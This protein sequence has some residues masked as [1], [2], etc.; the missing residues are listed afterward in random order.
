MRAFRY[1]G[2]PGRVVFGAGA[3]GEA[4]AEVEALGRSRALLLSTP[5]QAADLA[6]LA[7][8]LGPRAAGCFTAAA[9]H[10]PT[11][12]T[13]AAM[14]AY[15]Q[16][17]ADCVLALGGGSTIGLGKAIAWRNDAPQLVIATTYAGSEVTDI[18]GQTEDGVKTTLR[19]PRIRPET[20]IYDPELTLGLPVAMSVASGLNAMAHAIEGLYAPDANPVTSLMA[21]EGLRALKVALPVI[22]TAPHDLAARSRALY[23]SWL[24]GTVL[25]SVAMSLHHKLCHVLGGSFGL[26]HAETHAILLPHSAG[27]NAAA[28]TGQ[29]AE[30][31]QLFGGD[32][33][34]GL[35]DFAA[36]IGA[37][38]ALADL[39]LAETDVPRAVEIAL[40]KPYPNPRA[41][42][43]AGLND[44]LRGALA[45][46]RPVATDP[47]DIRCSTRA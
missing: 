29:L 11:Q 34:G 32:L 14:A 7:R 27:F 20:V 2:T 13:E 10:T 30:A 44:L 19:D 21:L 15:D 17:G 5:A 3:I 6:A 26:P 18:L 43:P 16:S 22:T 40:A 28:A 37:P 42:T 38:L 8:R 33:G 9:M 41:L 47:G 4:G 39:G 31:A 12:V 1:Q 36:D 35:W 23:G 25:G 45:G 24:C 46:T